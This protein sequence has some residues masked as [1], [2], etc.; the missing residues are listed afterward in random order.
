[1]TLAATEGEL[2]ELM[3]QAVF[4]RD[5]DFRLHAFGD[6]ECTVQVPF[7]AGLERPGGLVGGPAFMAAAD[8]AMWL[9]IATRLGPDDRSVTAELKTTFLSPARREDFLCTARILKLGRRMIYGVAECVASQGRL[10]THHTVT[11]LRP[12]A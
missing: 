6:G 3:A 9:A 2:R 8:I 4:A 7:R 10:L 12:D 5:Y 1:M 11:Y